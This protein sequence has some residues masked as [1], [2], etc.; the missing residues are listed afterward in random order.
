MQIN[1]EIIG[2]NE[3]IAQQK[4]YIEDVDAEAIEILEVLSKKPL[5]IGM[6]NK[7][8]IGEEVMIHP[9]TWTLRFTKENEKYFLTIN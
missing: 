4:Y 2:E 8:K 5:V 7:E 1:F 9:V 6:K 3:S